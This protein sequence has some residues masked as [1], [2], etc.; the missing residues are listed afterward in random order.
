MNEEPNPLSEPTSGLATPPKQHRLVARV[1][2]SQAKEEIGQRRS[3]LL[4]AFSS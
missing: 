2:P 1:G 4:N 3:L